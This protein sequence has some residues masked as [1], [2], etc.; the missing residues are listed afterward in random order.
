MFYPISIHL[1]LFGWLKAKLTWHPTYVGVSNFIWL[2]V[3]KYI[4][5]CQK[6]MKQQLQPYLNKAAEPLEIFSKL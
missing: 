6:K 3:K 5:H 2:K 1:A 4:K